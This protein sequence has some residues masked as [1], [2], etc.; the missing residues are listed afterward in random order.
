MATYKW[1]LAFNYELNGINE[2]G[3][4]VKHSGPVRIDLESNLE[5][6]PSIFEKAKKKLKDFSKKDL[7]NTSSFFGSIDEQDSIVISN[8]RLVLETEY[9]FDVANFEIWNKV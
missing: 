8:I 5:V 9:A 6:D 2:A 4:S 1:V 7:Q 3:Q